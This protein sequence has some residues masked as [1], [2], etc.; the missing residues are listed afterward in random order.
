MKKGLNDVSSTVT[1]SLHN[2]RSAAI[3]MT[4]KAKQTN[5]CVL[6]S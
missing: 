1:V 5:M 2:V 4:N 6:G 3:L